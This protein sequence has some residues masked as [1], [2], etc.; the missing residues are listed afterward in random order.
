M[1]HSDI[2]DARLEADKKK[3]NAELEFIKKCFAGELDV[4]G[5][6][7]LH[8]LVR[9]CR[10]LVVESHTEVYGST[11]VRGDV[12][13]GGK[14][15]QMDPTNNLLHTGSPDAIASGG[16]LV[17]P[18]GAILPFGGSEAPDGWVLCNGSSY[19]RTT[20]ADLFAVIGIAYGANDGSTFKVPDLRGRMCLGAGA[21][22]G[23]TNRTLAS[24]GGEET[25][26]LTIPEMPS[27]THTV[28]DPGHRHGLT[29]YDA[30]SLTGSLGRSVSTMG[31][32]HP[33]T[34]VALTGISIN[35]TGGDQPH[36]VMNPYL[37]VN[38]VIKY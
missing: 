12:Q 33:S 16:Y 4:D 9:I 10:D 7:I 6:T 5:D 25:H 35:P 21:G 1:S 26:Q 28:N 36:N 27:H 18:T 31:D 23:L 14:V 19:S 34:D 24:T 3:Y 2:G 32:V 38:Y 15:Y 13:A 11:R 29:A 17:M 22:S 30:G 20:Y 8:G 37:V